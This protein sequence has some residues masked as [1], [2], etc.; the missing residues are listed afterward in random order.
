MSRHM[1]NGEFLVG[2]GMYRDVVCSV[3]P[4]DNGLTLGSLPV[5]QKFFL[6]PQTGL[7]WM[8]NCWSC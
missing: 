6:S 5:P 8:L 2:F 1:S 7:S 3:Y 4:V